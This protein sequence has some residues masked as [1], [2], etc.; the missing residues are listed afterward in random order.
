MERHRTFRKTRLAER[1]MFMYMWDAG[2]SLR[3]IAEQTGASATTVRRWV[4]RWKTEMGF[5]S[6][7]HSQNTTLSSSTLPGAVRTW[8]SLTPTS[9]NCIYCY[10]NS[11]IRMYYYVFLREYLRQ[12]YEQEVNK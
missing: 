12:S 6:S 8:S 4:K 3:T 2:L 7:V 1:A 11:L 10:D 9:R 5:S